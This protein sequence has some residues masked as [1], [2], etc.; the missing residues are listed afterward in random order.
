MYRKGYFRQ[1]I[2][3]RSACSTDTGV[4]TDPDR[5]PAALV[6]GAP[7]GD[8][9]TIR[10]PV[11]GQ[12]VRARIWRVDVGRV[13]LFLLDTDVVDNDPLQRWITA[14]LYESDSDTRTV[15]VHA[16]G[17]RRHPRAARPR[18]RSW[19]RPPER[20]TRG[21]RAGW[22]SRSGMQDGEA[23][24]PRSRVLRVT[25][26]GPSS[27]PTRRSRRA[28]TRIRPTRPSA[29]S[30]CSLRSQV[31]VEDLIALGRTHASDRSEP[32]G[33]PQAALRLTVCQ[34]VSRRHGEVAREMW[35]E[36]VAGAPRRGGPHRPRHQ[37]RPPSDL[38]R[39]ADAP[40]AG[41]PSRRRT[42]SH[43]LRIP[44]PG[45][46]W[47]DLRTRSSGTSPARARGADL[48]RDGAATA[49]RLSRGDDHEYVLSAARALRPTS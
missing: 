30:S 10:V 45:R 21:P 2:D 40:A 34:R 1:R 8:P 31:P 17:N 43:A 6:T 49:D 42:G 47:A 18:H 39:G 32:F 36:S 4:D 5:T 28:T 19:R 44:P 11:Y 3:V 26:T 46:R 38:A 35:T 33:V 41:P 15:A 23:L 48:V 27:R 13:P 37:R 16:V 7:D 25:R 24:H 20:G 9:L 14:R 29:P 12:D 22:S